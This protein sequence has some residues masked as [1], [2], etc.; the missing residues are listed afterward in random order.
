MPA[1]TAA[2]LLQGYLPS[3]WV[4]HP[5]NGKYIKRFL[6]LAESRDIPVFW[7]LPPLRPEVQERATGAVCPSK[8]EAFVRE[9]GGP[10][11]EPSGAR[12]PPLKLSGRSRWWT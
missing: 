10:V 4:C 8:Y 11:S 2:T 6:S 1:E 7:L 9:A 5:V 3:D 12:W